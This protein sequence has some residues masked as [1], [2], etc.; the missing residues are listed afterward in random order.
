MGRQAEVTANNSN[1][2]GYLSSISGANSVAV[3]TSTSVTSDNSVAIGYQASVA[4]DNEISIGNTSIATIGGIVNWT[5]TSDGRFKTQVKEDIPGLN[6][7]SDL[8]PVS[9]NLNGELIEKFYG[10]E[11]PEEL[12]AAYAA[13]KEVRYSGFIAQ[14]VQ[15]SAEK[16]NYEFS[17]VKVPKNAEN[18]IYGL[19]YAEFVVPMVK[20]IQELEDRVESLESEKL[21]ACEKLNLKEEIICEQQDKIKNYEAVL[22]EMDKRIK[23]IEL[24]VASSQSNHS[25]VS[26]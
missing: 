1:A 19:R 22:I 15:A 17:G 5:A 26:R 21:M 3:G 8:R 14:E 4:S 11:I 7:I 16:F 6:F 24:K 9:Y 25:M 2:I 12:K 10:K 18:D 13:Q 20:A 23:A